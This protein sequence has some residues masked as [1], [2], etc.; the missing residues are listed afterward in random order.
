MSELARKIKTKADVSIKSKFSI[1]GEYKIVSLKPKPAY[2]PTKE[3]L[4]MLRMGELQDQILRVSPVHK[5]LIMLDDNVGLNLVMQHL[6]GDDTFPLAIN[7]AAIGTGTTAPTAADTA[8]QTPVV[9]GIPRAIG[10]LTDVDTLYTEWFI[11]NDELANGEYT[12]FGLYCG[13]QLFSRSLISGPT[14]TKGDNEDTLIVYTFVATN[15]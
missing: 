3:W 10:E 6:Q 2:V 12:E 5:N 13:T 7:A 11:S 8:L 1:R 15:S 9:T 14:H 4:K